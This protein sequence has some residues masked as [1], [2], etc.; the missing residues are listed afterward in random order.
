M[1]ALSD[2]LTKIDLF[3]KLA[4]GGRKKFLLALAQNTGQV[5]LPFDLVNNINILSTQLGTRFN[6]NELQEELKSTLK[7]VLVS[8]GS[9]KA[10]DVQAYFIMPANLQ[11]LLAVID[12]VKVLY[13]SRGYTN[14]YNFASD[15]YDKIKQI[16]ASQGTT[17]Q[18]NGWQGAKINKQVQEDLNTIMKKENPY[19]QPLVVDSKR[20]EKTEAALKWYKDNH[21]LGWAADENTIF[22]RLHEDAIKTETSEPTEVPEQSRERGGINP[23]VAN[24]H[25]F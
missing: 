18:N 17:S 3:E 10:D 13:N 16:S 14:P 6:E 1:N 22:A 4:S 7:T 19:M 20:G 21:G 23:T 9:T 12:K 2:L 8:S 24:K 15:L 11:P 25:R 5:K